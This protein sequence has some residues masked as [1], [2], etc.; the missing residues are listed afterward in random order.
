VQ[1]AR[2]LDDQEVV[3]ELSGRSQ[4][5]GA[6]PGAGRVDVL[7]SELGHQLLQGVHESAL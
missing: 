7:V 3:D 5:L 1:R 4:Q 6:H 2:A